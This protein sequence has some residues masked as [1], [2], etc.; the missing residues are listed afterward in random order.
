MAELT[1]WLR[2]ALLD[3]GTAEERPVLQPMTTELPIGTELFRLTRAPDEAAAR[4]MLGSRPTFF[5]TTKAEANNYRSF[6]DLGATGRLLMIH[7]S[8]LR[9]FTVA[10][11]DQPHVTRAIYVG[12]PGPYGKVGPFSALHPPPD[13]LGTGLSDA[14]MI[15]IQRWIVPVAVC[16]ALG[17]RISALARTGVPELTVA[18]PLTALNL[19]FEWREIWRGSNY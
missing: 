16:R 18:K 5:A 2:T 17:S 4:A 8:T 9:P 14:P 10:S 11:V 15:R 3:A 1:Q 12:V 6:A 13:G 19:N 7:G